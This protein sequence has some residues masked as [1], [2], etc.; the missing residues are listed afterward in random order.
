[1]GVLPKVSVVLGE[2]S[3]VSWQQVF[4]PGSSSN[5]S[6]MSPPGENVY[7]PWLPPPFDVVPPEDPN[8]NL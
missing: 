2:M 8:V 7:T 3:V 5:P 1:M 4:G 6:I